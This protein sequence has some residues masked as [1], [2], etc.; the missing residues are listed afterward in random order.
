MNFEQWLQSR[1]TAHGY[2]VGT[3][4][5]VIGPVTVN[6]LKAFQKARGVE[7]T[8]AA[9]GTTVSFLRMPASTVLPENAVAGRDVQ[10][11]TEAHQPS[12]TVWPRQADC[13]SFY[14]PVGQRQTTID[15]PFDMYLAWDKGTRV[16]K[17]TLHEKVAISA[18]I[19]LNKI[20]GIYSAAERKSLGIDL[21][22]GSLNVRRMRG[23]SSY[24]MHSWGIAI[25]FDPERN[26]LNWGR[27][28]AR[29]AQPDAVP[30]WVAWESEGWLS[31]GRAKNFDW[32]HVQ[33]ARL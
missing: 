26:Q 24:S 18:G 1:L 10:P 27:D 2:P 23:G 14:G 15:I 7:V 12:G 19:A 5:E 33:A 22:G 13:M 16:R 28:K 9:D 6:A 11:A 30:F 29:L 8:G 4:D 32:M 31:L 17:M 25:D 21:F 20:A 3:I